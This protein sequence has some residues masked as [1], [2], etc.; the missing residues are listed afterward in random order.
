PEN[1]PEQLKLLKDKLASIPG[2]S[3]ASFSL[4]APVADNSASTS[5]NV[6]EKYASEKIDVEGKA[7]DKNYLKTYNLQLIAGRWID[8]NDDRNIDA[9]IPDSLKRYVF[10]LNEKA[11]TAL[12]SSSAGAAIGKYVTFGMYDITAPV[13]GVVKD[14]NTTSLH[15]AVTP[16]IMV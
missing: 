10:V 16:V 11:V 1:K 12:G 7:S 5:L 9:S 6:K 14:Y 3:D 13:I 8:D 4:G 2:V 15:E